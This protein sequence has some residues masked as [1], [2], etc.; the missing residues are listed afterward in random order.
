MFVCNSKMFWQEYRAKEYCWWGFWLQTRHWNSKIW[1]NSKIWHYLP[2]NGGGGQSQNPPNDQNSHSKVQLPINGFFSS[3]DLLLKKNVF[4]SFEKHF[5]KKNNIFN[6][7][8]FEKKNPLIG[9]KSVNGE[10]DLT[11]FLQKILEI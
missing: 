5:S 9:K 3:K 2:S 6:S 11:L 4:F 7:K 8:S 10:L 1:E